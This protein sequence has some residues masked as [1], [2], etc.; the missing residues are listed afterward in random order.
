MKIQQILKALALD[1]VVFSK[2]FT[3]FRSGS[4]HTANFVEQFFVITNSKPIKTRIGS[5]TFQ[6]TVQLLDKSL[7]RHTMCA[8]NHHINTLKMVDRF[9][10][11]VNVN[12]TIRYADGVRFK[13]VTRLVV[14]KTAALNVVGVIGQF[15]LNF[16]VY[17]TG[18][19]CCFLSFQHVKERF[20][21]IRFLV[22][23]LG[24]ARDFRDVPH[25]SR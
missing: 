19:F 12:C 5:S 17:T 21:G 9:H 22:D 4:S 7:T 1:G 16:M 20:W 6:N 25:F 14:S 24:L 18:Q 10:H 8:V 3:Y 11:I 13:N 15:N 23:A 2:K